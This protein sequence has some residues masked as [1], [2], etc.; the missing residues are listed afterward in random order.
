MSPLG[1]LRLSHSKQGNVLVIAVSGRLTAS[2]GDLAFRQEIADSLE[3]GER[4]FVLDF[5]DLQTLDSSGLGELMSA[6]SSVQ[7]AEGLMA[8]AACPR[9][10]LDLLR[11]TSV[12]PAGVDFFDTAAEAVADLG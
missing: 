12:E 8:W 7:I 3:Q 5:H 2:G 10:M 4:R 6:A 11:I 9:T 1:K